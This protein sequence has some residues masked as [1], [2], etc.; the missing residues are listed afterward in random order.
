MSN[1]QKL[2]AVATYLKWPIEN[3]HD[4]IEVLEHIWSVVI[5]GKVKPEKED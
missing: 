2:E 1:E 5:E 4:A 3:E